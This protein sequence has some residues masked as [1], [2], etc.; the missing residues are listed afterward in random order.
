MDYPFIRDNRPEVIVTFGERIELD[1]S[2]NMDRK[3]MTHRFEQALEK[4][5][6]NQFRDISTGQIGDYKILFK[7]HLKWY[8]Q[9]EQRLKR[10]DIKKNKEG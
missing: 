6:D 7:E 1:K 9:I 2:D 8:R 10:I 4:T 5:C 3:E